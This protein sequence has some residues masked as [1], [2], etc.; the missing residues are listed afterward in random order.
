VPGW[1][2][3]RL[4]EEDAFA[5]HPDAPDRSDRPEHSRHGSIHRRRRRSR[6]GPAKE[7]FPLPSVVPTI[8]RASAICVQ[9][10]QSIYHYRPAGITTSSPFFSKGESSTQVKGSLA[11]FGWICSRSPRGM[12]CGR[13]ALPREGRALVAA[14]FAMTAD[15]RRNRPGFPLRLLSRRARHPNW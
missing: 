5:R 1:R 9:A 13:G 7:S 15:H 2:N 11:C 4:W 3:L 12:N 8:L 14:T 6:A 10:A